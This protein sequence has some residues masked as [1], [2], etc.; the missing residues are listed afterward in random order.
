MAITAPAVGSGSSSTPDVPKNAAVWRPGYDISKPGTWPTAQYE[1][2]QTQVAA[3]LNSEYSNPNDR[4]ALK[5]ALYQTGY[6]SKSD[7]VARQGYF[8]Q[9]DRNAFLQLL[10]DSNADGTFYNERLN[11]LLAGKTSGT[12]GQPKTTRSTSVDFSDPKTAKAIVQSSFRALLGRDPS[13]AEYNQ[14]A[15]TLH[16]AEAA[17]PTVTTTTRTG[18]SSYNTTTT[19]GL[20]VQGSQMAIEEGI[21]ANANLETELVNKRINGYGDVIAKLAGF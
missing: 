11:G 20:N 15:K 13:E 16:S 3:I 8:G 14:F 6:I 17:S 12:S 21:K 7:Y 5:S 9:A 10:K 19:G 4:D 18:T 2:T 1:L